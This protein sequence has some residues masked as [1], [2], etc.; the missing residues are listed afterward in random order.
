[1]TVKRDW[2]ED[3]EGSPKAVTR[4]S[5]ARALRVLDEERMTSAEVSGQWDVTDKSRKCSLHSRHLKKHGKHG[6]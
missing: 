2:A 6:K 3:P 4:A 5:S 1:M